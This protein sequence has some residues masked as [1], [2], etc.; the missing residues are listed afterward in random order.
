MVRLPKRNQHDRCPSVG[1]YM[2]NMKALCRWFV[3]A[4]AALL[5][6]TALLGAGAASK[7]YWEDESWTVTIAQRDFPDVLQ[8]DRQFHP[9][10]HYL[11]SA[12]WLRLSGQSEIAMRWFSIGCT[13]VTLSVGYVLMR[14]WFGYKTAIVYLLLMCVWPLMLTYAQ[15]A[16]YYPWQ[17]MLTVLAIFFVD[18]YARGAQQR[19]LFGYVLCGAAMITSVYA[20]IAA[21]IGVWVW[22]ILR[23]QSRAGF[24]P[25]VIAN[26]AVVIAFLPV[27]TM[28][29]GALRQNVPPIVVSA[30]L[31]EFVSR[32][33][34][35]SYGLVVGETTSPL[36]PM[37]WFK[38]CLVGVLLLIVLA[39]MRSSRLARALI[40]M[41]S[42]MILVTLVISA[43]AVNAPAP[44][45]I[46]NRGLFITPIFVMLLAWSL[47]S[48]SV[49]ARI[50]LTALILMTNLYSAFN[51]FTNRAFLKTII[52]VPWQQVMQTVKASTGEAADTVMF[53][54]AADYTCFFY[55][56]RYGL[57]PQ[58][59]S[60]WS[61]F[62]SHPPK[63]I[64]WLN[65]NST[66]EEHIDSGDRQAFAAVSA[67]YG[68]PQ[69]TNVAPQ[70]P[71]IIAFK[72]RL[73]LGGT[74]DYRLNIWHFVA[75]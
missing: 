25:W 48:V 23:R 11:I 13:A 54:N 49:Q 44:Q 27:S 67:V 58:L 5:I 8:A 65:S 69:V 40:L 45:G 70:D 3:P 22:F 66:N 50:T 24:G 41:L 74:Y 34:L 51:Y 7:A 43:S 47:A 39:R 73:G 32:S 15:S 30:F 31:R 75:R 21:I 29:S 57:S 12:V 46:I 17:M 56:L 28:F 52:T 20:S 36:D 42:V 6:Q 18:R 4:I 72:R 10:L 63:Q 64:W 71:S 35:L 61:T 38:A 19:W 68:D 62:A 16:R 14:R 59:P 2:A 60:A 55:G 26:L 53:C 37:A 9:P 1:H 33:A